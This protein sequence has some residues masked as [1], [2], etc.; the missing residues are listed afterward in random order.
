[1]SL[2]TDLK[3]E[4]AG[5]ASLEKILAWMQAKQLP[6]A[7]LDLVAQDEFCHDLFVPWQDR[8]LIFGLT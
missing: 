5:L 1:M 3:R 6:L 7:Q 2:D 8:W 4:L